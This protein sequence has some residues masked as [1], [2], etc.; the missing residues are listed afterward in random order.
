MWI[1]SITSMPSPSTQS[2]TAEQYGITTAVAFL[3]RFQPGGQISAVSAG[4]PWYFPVG[5]LLGLLATLGAFG[6]C[7]LANSPPIFF[8]GG[9]IWL[10]LE[11][12]LSR[13]LHWDGVAD[14]G[15]ALGSGKKGAAFRM[16]LKDSRLG[17]FGALSL[18]VLGGIQAAA[19]SVHLCN[20]TISDTFE[21]ILALI[22]APAFARNA[23][24]WLGFGTIAHTS[25][26]LGALLC[27][28]I[29][30]ALFY[31]GCLWGILALALLTLVGLPLW[32]TTILACT[33]IFTT[34]HI[35][36]VAR[37]NGGMSGD[38][39]GCHI[40]LSQALFLVCTISTAHI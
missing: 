37:A 17:A 18:I 20:G 30:P 26:S 22:L 31:L 40:E 33:Q 3:T 6:I 29:T 2:E 4:L 32:Q 28:G 1:F 38:F 12:F 5:L 39:F 13:G 25:P 23:T 9:W 15:D 35:R 16:I 19:A 27:T 21:P 10:A 7:L 11:I 36:R 8:L 34:C 24:L 14:V